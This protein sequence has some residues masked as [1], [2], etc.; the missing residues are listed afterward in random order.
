MTMKRR[1]TDDDDID[2]MSSATEQCH[3]QR[4]GR[5]YQAYHPHNFMMIDRPL[6]PTK[7]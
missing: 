5:A 1:N 6:Q 2:T 3:P 7:S 4:P